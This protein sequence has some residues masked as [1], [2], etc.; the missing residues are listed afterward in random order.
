VLKQLYK[1]ELNF[2]SRLLEK[3]DDYAI[4]HATEA[5]IHELMSSGKLEELRDLLI[6]TDENRA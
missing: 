2:A 5:A 6:A 3:E 1:D 4:D